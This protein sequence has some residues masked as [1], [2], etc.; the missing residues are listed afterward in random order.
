MATQ[1]SPLGERL[2]RSTTAA[3]A[4]LLALGATLRAWLCFHDDGIYWPDEIYQSLE[5]AHRLVFGYG[6]IPWEFREGAR[7]WSFAGIVA[8]LLRAVTWVG[9][10]SPR[11]YLVAMRLV[12][13]ALGMLTAFGVY[14][15]ARSCGA[16]P[17]GAA[18]GAVLF[19]LAPSAIYFAPRALSETGSAAALVFGLALVWPKNAPIRATVV[20]TSLVGLSVLMRL[21]NATFCVG[22][23]AVLLARREWRRLTVASLVATGWAILYGALDRLTWGTWFHAAIAY[24]RAN[25]VENKGAQWGVSESTYFFRVFWTSMPWIAGLTVIFLV[26]AIPRAPGLFAI[27]ALNL[28]MLSSVDHKEYRFA[29]PILPLAF[30]LAGLGYSTVAAWGERIR[31]DARWIAGTAAAGAA[32]S[33]AR[34]HELTFGELGQYERERPTAS[35]FDDFGPLNRL[36]LVAHDQVDLCG[37]MIEAAHLAWTGGATYLHRP[38]PIYSRGD[39]RDSD[40]FNYVLTYGRPRGGRVVASEGALSLI[41]I[42]PACTPDPS[43]RWWLP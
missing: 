38:V 6:L 37:I 18:L 25:V 19:A 15:L 39:W 22:L 9:G 12:F 20:G 14:R 23:L 27:L 5:P 24:L 7:N 8:A 10:D 26:V 1:P 3:F 4:A 16:R 35:A 33:G 31:W 17:L 11:Y 40:H 13:S 30:A 2:D 21:Q 43:Y 28:L 34:F 42:A 41:N 29:L 32:V 36:L